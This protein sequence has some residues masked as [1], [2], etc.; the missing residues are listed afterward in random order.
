SITAGLGYPSCHWLLPSAFLLA[1]APCK[2]F[3]MVG[4]SSVVAFLNWYSIVRGSH[5]LL[6]LPYGNPVNIVAPHEPFLPRHSGNPTL[7]GLSN[8]GRPKSPL[9]YRHS[10]KPTPGG[11][12]GIP[13]F[14]GM[15]V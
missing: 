1:M 12:S 3:Q 10:G 7:G 14:G 4:I 13:L 11:L 9:P 5:F 8:T 6:F 15:P 2:I